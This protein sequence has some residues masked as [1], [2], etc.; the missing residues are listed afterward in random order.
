MANAWTVHGYYYYTGNLSIFSEQNTQSVPYL[1]FYLD[2]SANQEMRSFHVYTMTIFQ[3]R[4][5][6]A[7]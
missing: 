7:T 2:M 4:V 1:I 6:D 5:R 3:M